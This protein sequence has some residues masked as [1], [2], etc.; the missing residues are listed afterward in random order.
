M[1]WIWG[2]VSVGILSEASAGVAQAKPTC[3]QNKKAGASREPRIGMGKSPQNLG[4]ELFT[5]QKFLTVTGHTELS[6]YI[7]LLWKCGANNYPPPPLHNYSLPP[8]ISLD[9][10]FTIDTS[11]LA[12]PISIVGGDCT[13]PTQSLIPEG[14]VTVI[15]PPTLDDNCTDSLDTIQTK[16][17]NESL[18]YM[19]EQLGVKSKCIPDL[20]NKGVPLFKSAVN[21]VLNSEIAAN[22]TDN[23]ACR[24]IFDDIVEFFEDVYEGIVGA[25]EEVIEE[26]GTVV[27]GATCDVIAAGALPGYHSAAVALRLLNAVKVPHS[28][29]TD[30]NFFIHPLHGSVY[31]DDI[32]IYY[33]STFP[34]G[35]EGRKGVT[36]GRRIYTRRDR[37]VDGSDPDFFPVIRTLLHE[38]AH[39]KQYRSAGFSYKD[40][41]MEK[42]ARR[43]VDTLDKLFDRRGKEFFRIWR[44]NNLSA[45]LGLPTAKS[46]RKV[47]ELQRGTVYSLR[48]QRGKMYITC[49]GS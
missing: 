1:S 48:L 26:I 15:L 19:L 36:F 40:N 44:E 35:F 34:P 39:V 2:S 33:D 46:Y 22:E 18:P 43:Q 9:R 12:A 24:G 20:V 37:I 14:S 25:G 38:F 3:Q 28:T 41:V 8:D 47:A 4:S 5:C 23:L 42:D 32:R 7:S 13:A 21:N 29:T 45:T 10:L 31:K 6:A 49:R 17:L 11:V 30:Q 16:T 27:V